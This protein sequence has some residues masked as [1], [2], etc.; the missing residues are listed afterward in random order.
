MKFTDYPSIPAFYR[1]YPRDSPLPERIRK[2]REYLLEL[3]AAYQ[4]ATA[5][6]ESNKDALEHNEMVNKRV[7]DLMNEVGMPTV[8][9]VRDEKSR[10]RIRPW[11]TKTAGWITDLEREFPLDDGFAQVR[12]S[13]L[14]NKEEAEA[15][16]E[17]LAKEEDDLKRQ[18]ERKAEKEKEAI[19][20]AYNLAKIKIKHDLSPEASAGDALDALFSKD[21]LLGLA[22]AMAKTRNDWSD[23]FY[24]VEG[25]LVTEIAEEHP[26]VF[27]AVQEQLDY[28]AIHGDMDGRV[29]RDMEYNYNVLFGMVD[30]D[31]Y[32]D[33]KTLTQLA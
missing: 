10:A 18:Q 7:H 8:Y 3:E 14:R 9:K 5:Q 4:K 17:E 13:Y 24:R 26:E 20:Y 19:I 25:A 15:Q 32:E 22:H 6:R 1:P 21:A 31:L 23:G 27:A 12:A 30:P 28:A 2:N 11:L 29:F 16:R 33:Y